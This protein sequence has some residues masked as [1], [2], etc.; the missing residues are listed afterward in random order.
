[1]KSV[2]TSRFATTVTIVLALLVAQAA[3]LYAM[4]RTPICTC[5]TVKFWHGVVVS[6]ENSQHITDWYTFSHIIHGFI[7]YL[8]GWLLLPR[9]PIGMRLVFALLIEGAW[10]LTENTDFIISRYREGTIALDYFGDSILNS[11]SDSLAMIVG[12]LIAA[13]LPV[14]LVVAAAI[15]MEL[16]V[17]YIIRD[18]LLLNIIMLIHPVDWIRQWQGGAG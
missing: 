18:N 17:G 11:V 2:Q 8:V 16:A 4:G 3:I 6:S 5:G 12:F 7:F 1:M 14:W 13:W 9:W 15:G 10:E